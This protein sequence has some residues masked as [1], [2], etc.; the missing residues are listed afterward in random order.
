MM[1]GRENWGFSAISVFSRCSHHTPERLRV[2][3]DI[4]GQLS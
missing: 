2:M 3:I 1:E 4:E